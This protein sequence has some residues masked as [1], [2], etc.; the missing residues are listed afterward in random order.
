MATEDTRAEYNT[1]HRRMNRI[2]PRRG[3]CDFCARV[4]R[5]EYASIGHQYSRWLH[6]WLE[7]CKR[8]HDAFDGSPTATRERAKTHCYRGHPFDDE[9][10]YLDGD[11]R[12]CRACARDRRRKYREKKRRPVNA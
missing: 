11:Y 1:L 5:T 6:D 3:R 8:C 12:R 4:G 2:F 7:L 9:N 10:T